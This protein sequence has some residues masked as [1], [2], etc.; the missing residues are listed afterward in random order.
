MTLFFLA[1]E[2]IQLQGVKPSQFQSRHSCCQH[3]HEGAAVIASAVSV[4]P[5]VRVRTSI[6]AVILK[7]T[8]RYTF[9]NG[10]G[11]NA[12]ADHLKEPVQTVFTSN[13]GRCVDLVTA[14][15]YDESVLLL[16]SLPQGEL[17]QHLDRYLFPA[18]DVE[19]TQAS[20]SKAIEVMT[21]KPED[22]ETPPGLQ[23]LPT[24]F[25]ATICHRDLNLG[26][27]E[28]TPGILSEWVSQLGT[29]I[30]DDEMWENERI[31]RGIPKLGQDVMKENNPL[32]A[33]LWHHVSFAKGCYIGQETIARLNTYNGVKQSLC[34][35]EFPDNVIVGD[36]IDG[37]D[38]KERAA[39][40]ITSVASENGSCRALGYLR[41]KSGLT[42]AGS[43][44]VAHGVTGVTVE[45]PFLKNG[46]ENRSL[47]TVE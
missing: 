18:D 33:G 12:F 27:K 25:G 44:I 36:K 10:M 5:L 37:S 45:T 30:H 34:L 35:M 11:T 32:E 3:H 13:I 17:F 38:E 41:L 24:T 8:D 26:A 31:S 23:L 2:P 14:I 7:G 4:E 29:L 6:P 9:V 20:I 43:K 28:N 19:I 46:Y 15:Q 40:Y 1:A 42:N 16:S 22:I 39:G 21:M 47:L